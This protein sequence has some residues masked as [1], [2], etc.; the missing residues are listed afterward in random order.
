MPKD[1]DK[2][3]G[4]MSAYAFFV[5][6]CREE[7]KKKHP[8]E[9]V[10]F[11]EFSKKCSE[12]WKTM[13]DKEKHRFHQLAEKDKKRYDGEM[14]NYKP[15]KGEGRKK[16]RQ[17]DPDAPKRPL[18]AFFWFCN[19]ERPKVKATMPDSTVGDVAKELGRRWNECTED[20]KSKYEALAAK[21][22]AR[23]EKELKAYKSGKPVP[24]KGKAAAKPVKKVESSEEEEDESEEEEDSD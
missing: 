4:R 7:H 1:A 17:K 11:A 22:K 8:S 12:R 16:K 5:Q 21:D 2:P 6:T 19:D 20:Q 13:S 14:A 23:Y 9:S 24:T 10:V 18:S 3:R 15:K